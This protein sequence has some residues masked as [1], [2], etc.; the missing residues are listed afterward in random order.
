[1]LLGVTSK[2][3]PSWAILLAFSPRPACRASLEVQSGLLL[4]CS[5][6]EETG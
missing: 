2:F 3:F 1:M 6:D 4:Y 5:T